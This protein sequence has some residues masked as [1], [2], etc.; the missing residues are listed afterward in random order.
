[1]NK[2]LK[3]A[4]H[5]KIYYEK[6]KVKNKH[7]EKEHKSIMEE[8]HKTISELVSGNNNV[9]LTEKEAKVLMKKE[10]KTIQEAINLKNYYEKED[11]KKKHSEK[12]NKSIMEDLHKSI[13][14]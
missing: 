5:L 9:L 14:V 10:N 12:E 4:I 3:E 1:M 13:S 7:S 11:V 6:E 2:T 8:L